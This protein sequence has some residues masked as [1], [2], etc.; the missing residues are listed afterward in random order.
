[1]GLRLRDAR[2]DADPEL[3][4]D[5]RNRQCVFPPTTAVPTTGKVNVDAAVDVPAM[6]I[7]CRI[8]V[9]PLSTL[10]SEMNVPV[11]LPLN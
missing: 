1:M 3:N 9:F 4:D 11:K 2:T 6:R 8:H 7:V 5:A 10:N